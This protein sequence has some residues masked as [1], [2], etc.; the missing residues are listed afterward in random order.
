MKYQKEKVKKKVPFKITSKE[1]K[2]LRI[3]LTKRV[4]GIC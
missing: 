2:Y 4:K 1:I 3:N